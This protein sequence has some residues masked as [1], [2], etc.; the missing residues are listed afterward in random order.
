[1]N[2]FLGE[3]HGFWK[4]GTTLKTKKAPVHLSY[5]VKQ[6]TNTLLWIEEQSKNNE[7]HQT[8]VVL[9]NSSERGVDR[10]EAQIPSQRRLCCAEHQ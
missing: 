1:M 10:K 2:F 9:A 8:G 3:L 5:D 4:N 6:R 7:H